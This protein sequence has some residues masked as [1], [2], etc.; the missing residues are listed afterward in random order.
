L[1]LDALEGFVMAADPPL[2]VIYALLDLA[3]HASSL[4]DNQWSARL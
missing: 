3:P 1:A 2:K 4:L